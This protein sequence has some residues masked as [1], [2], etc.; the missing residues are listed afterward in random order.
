[1]AMLEDF[2]LRVF[3]TVAGQKSFS[4]AAQ[5]LRI[6]QPAVSQHISEL[7][8]QLGVKL[9]QRQYGVTLLTPAGEVFKK[10]AD[11][12][13]LEYQDVMTMFTTLPE[14]VVK[15]WAS[16][17]V[18]DHVMS[19]ILSDFSTV[20]PEITFVKSFADDADISISLLP[21]SGGRGTFALECIP[22]AA[23]STSRLW[24]V[25]SEIFIKV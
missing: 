10:H 19:A 3:V 13:L 2:R 11:R 23:F 16:E 9:F 14:K 6:S 18:Y 21:K 5:L 1:M 22:S 8:K 12:I 4:K 7:E 15:V 20:H 24:G 17:E 25:I